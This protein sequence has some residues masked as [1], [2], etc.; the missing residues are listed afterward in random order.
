MSL[1]E[2]AGL[3]AKAKVRIPSQAKVLWQPDDGLPAPDAARFAK[4]VAGFIAAH[5]IPP[6]HQRREKPWD[7]GRT[8]SRQLKCLAY[9]A[10]GSREAR[11]EVAC[12]CV[13]QAVQLQWRFPIRMGQA[14]RRRNSRGGRPLY[15]SAVSLA[16]TGAAI[17]QCADA[18]SLAREAAGQWLRTGLGQLE[19]FGDRGGKA[20]H[21]TAMSVMETIDPDAGI[22][23]I[24]GTDEQFFASINLERPDMEDVARHV[25]DD[26]WPHAKEAYVGALV[27]RFS[28]DRGWPDVNLWKTVD[29]AE[30]HDICRNVF[31]L[32]AH[33]FRR[34]DFGRE[35]DWAKIIDRDI[36]SRVWMNAHPWLL[37]LLAAHRATGD[38]KYVQHLCRLLNSWYETS[39]PTFTR[40]SAQWRTL[41]AGN[42]TGQRWPS[43]LLALSQHPTF[44]RECLFNVARSM[45]D[46]GKYLS[47]YSAG[48]GNW[49]QV[50]SSGL[51][52][53]A[54]LFP[55]FKLSPLF[56]ETAMDRLAWVNARS[57]LP[58]G[59][60]SE[61][62]PGYHYFPLNGIAGALR[63]ANFLR[64]PLPES[65]MKQYEDGIVVLQ[66][67]AYPDQTL[68][69]LSD[70]N[71]IRTNAKAVF[72]TGAQ[73]FGREDSR[74]LAT[75]GR[76]GAPPTA[77]SHDFKYAGYCVMRDK[78][79][80][81]GQMLLFDA[82][83]FGAGHQH[84][85]K[86]SFV[87]YAG[88]RELIGDPGIYSYKG[89]ELDPYWRG[90]WSHNTIV[91]DGLSQHRKLGPREA[92]PDPDRRFVMGD[93]FD[94]ATGWYRR[95]YSPRTGA[96]WGR[97]PATDRDAVIRNVQH[98]RCIFYVKG[99]YAIICDRVLGAG[100]RPVDILFHPAPVLTGQGKDRA[101]RAA[102]L[103]VRPDGAVVTTECDHA[104]VAI[105]PAQGKDMKVLDLIG[106]KDPVR[107]WY[108][109]YAIV[110]SHDIVCRSRAKLPRHFETVVQPLLPPGDEPMIVEQRDVT[111]KAGKSCA[112]LNCG[113]DLF[114]ISHD[115][116][117]DM[118]CGEV[119]FH[120]TA[121]LLRRNQRGRP[122]QAQ[123][124]DGTALAIGERDVL[125]SGVPEPA[126]SL[127][128]N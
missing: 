81:D 65:L 91:I 5:P 34:H 107:G 16:L 13:A 51:A 80:P 82:G 87:F 94:F 49:L 30:A 61:C 90:S 8:A 60:Q 108:A 69:M 48:G 50:E 46:H 59:F 104:N 73:V 88:G 55:E 35:V 120:G 67:V 64:A 103:E 39:P 128:L 45:L 102:N 15:A 76:E 89:D 44:R 93:G 109:L 57:F 124:V 110:P 25:A 95:A 118:T 119:R 47:M 116:P 7:I 29:L 2:V 96:L 83:Y 53:V 75:D 1:A 22:R 14:G 70:W 114:L 36:E 56:Y 85:D 18:A 27:E 115:G 99:Q 92:M 12:L 40:S 62:S 117:T 26:D 58:D 4:E 9:L 77:L 38:D 37:T 31:I 24:H 97:E 72:E 19:T 121:L 32:K 43:V 98:Q 71:P 126:R 20:A 100:E 41:E 111:S 105:L 33:M 84:E 21:A 3:L 11:L 54:L 106:Q 17:W 10:D 28:G 63:L 112:G 52:C 127:D 23:D 66:Q 125:A 123:M 101:V 42:R 79:G 78:W 74:W 113:A 6:A 86:L 122:V 68:P